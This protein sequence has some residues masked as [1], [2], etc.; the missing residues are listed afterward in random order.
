M[1]VMRDGFDVEVGLSD[2]TMDI[3]VSVAA[4]ALGACVIEKHFTLSRADGGV[5]SAFSLEKEELKSLVVNCT[6]AY[7]AIGKPNFVSTEAELQTKCHRRSLYIV[8]DIKEDEVFTEEHV[9]SIRPGNGILPKYLDEVIGSV[10]T[11]DL[12]FGTPLQ[13][14]HFV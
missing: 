4:V 6:M 10:A 14:S 1:A 9:R 5:D 8:K 3:G 13:F 12:K 7:E 2:H 11:Q